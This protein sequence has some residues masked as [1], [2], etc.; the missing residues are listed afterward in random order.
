MSQ[1]FEPQRSMFK[2]GYLRSES[3]SYGI[4]NISKYYGYSGNVLEKQYTLDF[5]FDLALYLGISG[6]FRFGYRNK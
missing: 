4:I 1:D 3:I 2:V 5:G 6:K